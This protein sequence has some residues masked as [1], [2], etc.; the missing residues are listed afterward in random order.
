MEYIRVRKSGKLKG[1]VVIEGAKNAALPILAATILTKEEIIISGVP[2]LKDVEIMIEVI[3]ALGGK[4]EKLDEKTLKI[5]NKN[6][7]KYETPYELMDKMRASFFVMGPLLARMGKTYTKLPGGCSIG[8]RPVD[9]HLKGF[10][11]LGAKISED[12]LVIGAE[13]KDRLKG[14]YVYLDFPSVG[15]TENIMMAATLAEG[16][17]IIDNAAMEPEIVDL[18][19]MLTKMGAKIR[20]VGTQTITIE[21]VSELKGAEHTI[22]PDRI[23]AGTYMV[24]AAITKGDVLIKNVVSSHIRPIIAKLREMGCTVDVNDDEDMVRVIGTENLKAT[25][26]KTLPYPGFPTD[27]QSQ[28]MTLMT[29]CEGESHVEETVFENRFMHVDELRKMSALI[30]TEGKEARILG[31]PSLKGAKVKA[32]DLRAGA[33]CILAGLVAEGE[34]Y[35]YD[36]YHIYRGYYDVIQKFKNLGADIEIIKED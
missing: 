15:A 14:N 17:T 35:I 20:G 32:T 6:I 7:T 13:V 34:T 11:A 24:A 8:A 12:S 4:V 30:L 22:I 25:H 28:F 33:S 21:G 3:E 19:N 2:L 5:N 36:I 16:E 26:I 27:A 23:E 18:A 10:K 31:V 1:E 29:I 9:L